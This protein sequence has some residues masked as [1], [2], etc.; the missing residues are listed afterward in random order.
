MLAVT[1]NHMCPHCQGNVVCKVHD[2]RIAAI[3]SS[4]SIDQ[5]G[6]QAGHGANLVRAGM[7]EIQS[8]W[9]QRRY[10]G[11]A[12]IRRVETLR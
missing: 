9:E 12:F 5:S 8:K 6:T 1:V 2:L 3:R 11:V 7:L 4:R 10:L